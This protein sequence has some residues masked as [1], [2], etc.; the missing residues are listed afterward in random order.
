M[1]VKEV[2]PLRSESNIAILCILSYTR[3]NAVS[4]IPELY[5]TFKPMIKSLSK[6][7][8]SKALIL[9]ADL[10][11]KHRLETVSIEETEDGL[12]IKSVRKTKSA[13]EKKLD[14]LKK[15]K[16]TIYSKM[17]S[18]ANEKATKALYD[19]NEYTMGNIALDIID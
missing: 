11:K 7:G 8:N 9:P 16:K 17:K 1:S 18:Q 10:I 5:T 19:N 4:T 6:V 2:L 14:L 13:F 12:L 15:N 3:Y